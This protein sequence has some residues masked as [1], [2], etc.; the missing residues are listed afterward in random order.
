M[1]E[2]EY[3]TKRGK[4]IRFVNIQGLLDVF[5]ASHPEPEGPKYSVQKI[6]GGVEYHPLTEK[7]A[8]TEEEKLALSEHQKVLDV[9]TEKISQDFTNLILQ[10]GIE[11]DID[12]DTW[13]KEQ[14]QFGIV[15]PSEPSARRRHYLQTEVLTGSQEDIREDISKIISGVLN[16]SGVDREA[17]AQLEAIFRGEMGLDTRNS[18][19]NTGTTKKKKRK[20]VLQRKVS[21]SGRSSRE[22]E[23][24]NKLVRRSKRG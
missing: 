14:E 1:E 5:Y 2:N 17:T 16:A 7:T 13:V 15:V 3:I 4:K 8:E 22:N 12:D 18:N 21:A 19:S 20:L 6:G 23:K 24:T 10:R 9:H 11:F